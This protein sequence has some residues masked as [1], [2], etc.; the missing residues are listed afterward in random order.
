MTLAPWSGPTTDAGRQ[1]ADGAGRG[2]ATGRGPDGGGRAARRREER[3]RRRRRF[4][5]RGAAALALVVAL[6][7]V[8]AVLRAGDDEPV[9]RPGA[10]DRPVAGATRTP[11]A[12]VVQGAL[13]EPATAIALV[14]VAPGGKGGHVVLLPPATMTEVPSFGLESLGRSNALG[15]PSLL[16]AAVENLFG[17]AVDQT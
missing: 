5:V 16:Q 10:V 13:G 15:G 2:S 1:D 4:L 3:R 8:A 7:L 14:A 6:V 17:I 11:T 12:M 9:L